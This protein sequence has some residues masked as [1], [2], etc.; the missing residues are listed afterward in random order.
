MMGGD[1]VDSLSIGNILRC[2]YDAAYG[3]E[4]PRFDTSEKKAE[5]DYLDELITAGVLPRFDKSGTPDEW[6][7]TPLSE[8]CGDD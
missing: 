7:V 2:L 6:G 5:A 8:G 1:E 3:A 4:K